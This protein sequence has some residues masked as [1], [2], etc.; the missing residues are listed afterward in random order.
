MKLPK[1]SLKC[2]QDAFSTSCLSLVMCLCFSPSLSSRSTMILRDRGVQIW[3]RHMTRGAED[4]YVHSMNVVMILQDMVDIS[5]GHVQW[6]DVRV[7]LELA[8][9]TCVELKERE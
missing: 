9:R 7:L 3:Q 2:Y 8:H 5:L 4:S 1:K 6:G